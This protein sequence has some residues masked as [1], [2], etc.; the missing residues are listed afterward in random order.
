YR[1]SNFVMGVQ[2]HPEFHQAG[3]PELLDCTPILDHFLRA[4]RD[5]RF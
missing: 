4:A 5:T 2:W 3:A 1:K